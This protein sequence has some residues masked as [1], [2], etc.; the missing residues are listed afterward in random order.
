MATQTFNLSNRVIFTVPSLTN[1]KTFSNAFWVLVNADASKT[2]EWMDI[3]V[4]QSNTFWTTYFRW[5]KCYGSSKDSVGIG[6]YEGGSTAYVV[7]SNAYTLTTDKS[8]WRHL[9]AVA[10]K[11]NNIVR[12]YLDGF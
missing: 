11:A 1:S 3:L 10:D 6:E 12:W 5:E 7:T 4:I 2:T 8:A 9:V